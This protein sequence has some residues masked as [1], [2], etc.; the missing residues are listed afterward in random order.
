V[1]RDA[2]IE[3]QTV[4]MYEAV[5]KPKA[6]ATQRLDEASRKLCPDLDHFVVFSSFSCG[7]G[8]AGQTNYGY[9]N[10]AAERVCERRFADGFPGKR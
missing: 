1:L 4:E 6:Y 7:R 3:N 10:A 5:W 8:N 2:L 9:A